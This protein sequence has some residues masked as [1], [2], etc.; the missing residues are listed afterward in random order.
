MNNMDLIGLLSW[1]IVEMDLEHPNKEGIRRA[2]EAAL[3]QALKE[4]EKLLNQ[5]AALIKTMAACDT[6]LV[7]DAK[8]HE[9]G[10][11]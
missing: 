10:A 4:Q 6:P 1:A 8:I 2:L 9:G 7:A 11:L 3:E 5:R